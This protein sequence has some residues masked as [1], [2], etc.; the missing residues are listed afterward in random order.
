[1]ERINIE[2][3]QNVI[4]E[5]DIANIGI[6][7]VAALIDLFFMF[8][9]FMFILIL[10]VILNNIFTGEDFIFVIYFIL[11]LPLF[12]YSIACELIFHGQTPGKMLIKIRVVKTDGSEPTFGSYLIRWILR[13]IDVWFASGVVAIIT[14]IINGKGQRLGDLAAGTS[15]VRLKKTNFFKHSFYKQLPDNYK[16]QFPEVEKLAEKDIKTINKVLKAY[17]LNRNETVRKLLFY[18]NDEVKKKM[19][20]DIEMPPL[21]LLETLIK[22]YNF[23]NS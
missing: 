8:V 4:I 18:A 13:L 17:R 19:N 10:L 16:L 1:M 7:I 11:M 2:T 23:I 22:D 14:V 12:F 20:I 3:T 15:V 21:L 9:Y 6:R 5:H